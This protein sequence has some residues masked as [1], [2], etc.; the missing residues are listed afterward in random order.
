MWVDKVVKFNHRSCNELVEFALGVCSPKC[1]KG[2]K[3]RANQGVR[4]IYRPPL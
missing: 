4:R 1:K 2:H 3:K